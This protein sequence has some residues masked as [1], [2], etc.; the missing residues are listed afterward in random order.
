MSAQIS[1]HSAHSIMIVGHLDV[2]RYQILSR[3][4]CP[5][6]RQCLIV[7]ILKLIADYCLPYIDD[8]TCVFKIRNV[9]CVW[10]QVYVKMFRVTTDEDP[11][12]DN[13]C[14]DFRKLSTIEEK[15]DYRTETVFLNQ[16]LYILAGKVLRYDIINDTW[17]RMAAMPFYCLNFAVT[18]YQGL[19][20]VSGGKE[21]FA[22]G[23]NANFHVYYPRKDCWKI[24]P[25]MKIPRSNHTM[26]GHK[27]KIYV[28]GGRG[29]HPPYPN[30]TTIANIFE[31]E[32]F[33]VSSQ[34]W[35]VDTDNLV[36]PR[37]PSR[38][39]TYQGV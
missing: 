1:R 4:Q 9:L 25:P 19:I 29:D 20:Y 27:G 34:S 5:E 38:L 17:H 13:G 2:P 30:D 14:N 8:S 11:W 18:T 35:N 24:L 6:L 3:L 31:C 28:V 36:D 23:T 10:V 26:V 37:K 32:C 33:D 39:Q 12:E 7:D 16:S 21:N 15:I 22:E